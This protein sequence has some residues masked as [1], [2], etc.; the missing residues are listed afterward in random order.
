METFGVFPLLLFLVVVFLY[1][2]DHA[3]D[4][5]RG[6]QS[7][8]LHRR[9][10]RFNLW[11]LALS[12]L[13]GLGIFAFNTQL[14]ITRYLALPLGLVLLYA[15]EFVLRTGLRGIKE[16]LVAAAVASALFYPFMQAQFWTLYRADVLL[17]FLICLQNMVV[18][19]YFEKSKD[20]SLGNFTLYRGW[21]E[22]FSRRF[23]LL[24][25][26]FLLLSTLY[27]QSVSSGLFPL[28]WLIP[29]LY[30]AMLLL[31]RFFRHRRLYRLVADGLLGLMGL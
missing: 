17:L 30:M 27:V 24:A 7:G 23:A 26:A 22:S 5:H 12:G 15:L 3:W 2:A 20:D 16:L 6:G 21:G 14:V 11:M 29:P 28:A 9:S 19:G 4:A 25:M 13:L 31:H 10:R 18:F 8:S 1:S